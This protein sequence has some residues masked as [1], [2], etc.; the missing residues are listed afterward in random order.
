MI[1]DGRCMIGFIG[2][3]MLLLRPCESIDDGETLLLVEEPA[4]FAKLPSSSSDESFIAA[5][6]FGRAIVLLLSLL[7]LMLA[8]E[9]LVRSDEALRVGPGSLRCLLRYSDRLTFFFRSFGGS[10]SVDC[11]ECNLNGSIGGSRVSTSPQLAVVVVVVPEVAD[12]EETACSL[13]TSSSVGVVEPLTAASSSS[14]SSSIISF[15]T[16]TLPP[17]TSA[18]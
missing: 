13:S 5:F 12:A 4:I 15:E 1:E 17:D 18:N 16:S 9:L 3:E 10:L 11:F 6:N 7:L 2:S 8:M 14:S